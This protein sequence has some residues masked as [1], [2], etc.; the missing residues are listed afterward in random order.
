M[1]YRRRLHNFVQSCQSIVSGGIVLPRWAEG[2]SLRLVVMVALIA[3]SL[4]YIVQIS[5]SAVS[6][7]E[8]HSLEK[9]VSVLDHDNEQMEVAIAEFSS[10]SSIN[11]RL[12]DTHMVPAHKITF[13]HA[14]DTLAVAKK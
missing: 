2:I 1:L 3:V 6:G 11:Q 5:Q 12:A 9:E 14:E 13:L 10:L 4:G 7:Y 8:I